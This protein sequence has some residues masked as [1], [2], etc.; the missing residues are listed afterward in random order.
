MSNLK[1]KLAILGCGGH[2][3]DVAD[4]AYAS[5]WAEV[6]FYDDIHVKAPNKVDNIGD[7]SQLINDLDLYDGVIV[8]IADN[9]ARVNKIDLLVQKGANLVNVIH[10]NAVFS[11]EA[12]ISYGCVLLSNCDIQPGNTIGYGSILSVNAIL[13]HDVNIGVGVHVSPAAILLGNV[14]I[15]N[16]S[17]V[18]TGTVIKENIKVTNEVT[19]GASS[20]VLE[21]INESG[22]Y[23]GIPVTKLKDKSL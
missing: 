13:G 11:R 19:I 6:Y 17:W 22:T 4:A 14:R 23:V 21:D 5:G 12:T 9:Y 2:G 10:P 7:T 8:A 3:Y 15:G 20:L 18:G 1:S 16:K